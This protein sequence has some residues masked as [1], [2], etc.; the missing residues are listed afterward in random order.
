MGRPGQ[1][2]VLGR[3]NSKCEGPEVA[4]HSLWL[5]SS[6]GPKWLDQHWGHEVGDMGKGQIRQGLVDCAEEF[7]FY[8]TCP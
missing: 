7:G 4:A 3:G 6:K 8:S 2:S 5:R 1:K